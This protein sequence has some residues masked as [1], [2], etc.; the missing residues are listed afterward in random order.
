MKII[1]Y[2]YTPDARDELLHNFSAENFIKLPLKYRKIMTIKNLEMVVQSI[3]S[4]KELR[5]KIKSK[6]QHWNGWYYNVYYTKKGRIIEWEAYNKNGVNMW[7]THYEGPY[8]YKETT[9]YETEMR[10]EKLENRVKLMDEMLN[11]VK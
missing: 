5:E 11:S 9:D 4:V 7:G 8:Y 1:G 3:N 6:Q 10:K 2:N